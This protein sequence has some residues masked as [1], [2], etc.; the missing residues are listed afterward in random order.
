MVYLEQN[1][2]QQVLYVPK[3]GRDA[4]G[5]VFFKAYSTIGQFGFS[6]EAVEDGTSLLYH[7]VLVELKEN[8][9]AGEYEYDLSDEAGVL[10]NGLLVIG[11]KDAKVEYLIDNEYEQYEE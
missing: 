9:P 5:K 10:S 4:R 8:I 7:K 3:N 2:E 11:D 1:T 6:F